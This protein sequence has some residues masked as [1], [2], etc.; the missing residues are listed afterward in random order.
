VVKSKIKRL[1]KFVQGNTTFERNNSNKI[2]RLP[3]TIKAPQFSKTVDMSLEVRE[4]ISISSVD[5]INFSANFTNDSKAYFRTS[6]L[7]SKFTTLPTGS[8]VPFPLDDYRSVQ[9]DYS[10]N[11][12]SNVRLSLYLIWY[13]DEARIQSMQYDLTS[14]ELIDEQNGAKFL[15]VPEGAKSLGA[16]LRV[17]GVG[18]VEFL[19]LNINLFKLK[20]IQVDPVLKLMSQDP[21]PFIQN[22]ILFGMSE[23]PELTDEPYRMLTRILGKRNELSILKITTK[24]ADDL[25]ESVYRLHSNALKRLLMMDELITYYQ[26]LPSDIQRQ[27]ILQSRYLTALNWTSK[28]DELHELMLQIM[29]YPAVNGT[30]LANLINYAELLSNDE[31]EILCNIIASKDPAHI[32]MLN[33][34]TFYD[35]LLHR[36]LVSTSQSLAP[37][38]EK[39]LRS[40]GREGRINYNLMLSNIAFRQKNYVDQLHY[41]NMAFKQSKILTVNLIDE[42]KPFS[43]DNI[44]RRKDGEYREVIVNDGPVVTIIMTTWNSQATLEYAAQS[45]LDQT[46]KNLEFIIVDDASSDDTPAL[47]KTIAQK[48]SRVVP[49]LLQ[50]NGGTY[51]A[52]NHGRAVAKGEFITCQ[53]SDD[54]AHPQKLALLVQ[55]L[56]EDDELVGVEC[57]HVRIAKDA[58]V[59]RRAAGAMRRDA[60]SL[61]Y[62]RKEIDETLG[63]YDNVRAGADGEFKFRMQRYYGVERTSYLKNLLSIVDWADGTLS[64]QGSEYAISSSGVFSPARLAYRQAFYRDHEYGLFEDGKASLYRSH[65]APA[66]DV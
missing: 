46:Y 48:D 34:L 62:R 4:E 66:I 24:Y 25:G 22:A 10:V 50:Q 9:I 23:Y 19:H 33:F 60:S 31:L 13:S 2:I 41:V 29:Q 43:V 52:K 61:M 14:S 8:V 17:S 58:G 40:G 16:A 42:R 21:D 5:A 37:L 11:L 26:S 59:Q 57:G 27:P 47:I 45:I 1:L 3:V 38:L 7:Q 36:G 32:E 6:N 54:W 65:D 20:K 64:G 51:V 55:T 44:Y 12:S 35:L 56:I 15:D 63:F 30:V 18:Q 53:D 28:N 39:K 49:I